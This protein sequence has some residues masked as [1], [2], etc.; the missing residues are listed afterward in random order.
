[1]NLDADDVV[2]RLAIAFN[3][4]ILSGDR[5]MV[6]YED[7]DN[8]S[9]RVYEHFAFKKDG[10]LVLIP[11]VDFE[12][13]AEP[14]RA[15]SVCL[16]VDEWRTPKYHTVNTTASTPQYV[17]GNPDSFT[18]AMDNLNLVARPL[19][20]ALY[21][22]LGYD[23]VQETFPEWDKE[24]NGVTWHATSVA[25]DSS[26]DALLDDPLRAFEWLANADNK[27]HTARAASGRDCRAWRSYSQA[28]L[29]AEYSFAARC[30]DTKHTKITA[31]PCSTP[32][33]H[34][35]I[36]IV[37]IAQSVDP[38]FSA[39]ATA[40]RDPW[41]IPTHLLEK[42][43]SVCSNSS[44]CGYGELEYLWSKGF[45]QPKLCKQCR[46]RRKK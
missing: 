38:R 44:N 9:Q 27:S 29:V 15:D 1:L 16:A 12:L 42:M 26:L 11:R 24:C 40:T 31:E 8:K 32:V 43:C 21:A 45:S 5:D 19:R 14:R 18:K 17:R 10:S 2:V 41:R 7:L 22:R 34:E 6:R 25:A 36:N 20:Q 4:V 13:R 28:M 35:L 33:V 37:R 30:G 46:K 39:E 23:V 3:G